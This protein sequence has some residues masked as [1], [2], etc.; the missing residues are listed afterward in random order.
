MAGIEGG[1]E[2]EAVIGLDDFCIGCADLR[3]GVGALLQRGQFAQVCEAILIERGNRTGGK[4]RDCIRRIAGRKRADIEG[5]Y[6]GRLAKA[7]QRVSTREEAERG[8]AF[9]GGDS[10]QGRQDRGPVLLCHCG[11][12]TLI[13]RAVGN[14]G[15]EVTRRLPF[16][17][18]SPQAGQS[19][20]SAVPLVC[21]AE[22]PDGLNVSGRRAGA[23]DLGGGRFRC[24]L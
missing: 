22:I 8:F 18:G 10:R 24:L 4:Y 17:I 15:A 21:G 14:I 6:R 16:G 9:I 2:L 23:D 11:G 1:I 3:V 12:D 20:F 7:F 13:E 19:V 5:R